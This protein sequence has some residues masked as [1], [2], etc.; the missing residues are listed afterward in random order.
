MSTNRMASSAFEVDDGEW[1]DFE[2]EWPLG[3]STV[4][5]EICRLLSTSTGIMST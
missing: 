1:D 5:Y 2:I 3:S 4:L